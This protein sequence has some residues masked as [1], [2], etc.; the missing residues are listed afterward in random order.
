MILKLW[1]MMKR[2][3]MSK[4]TWTMCISFEEKEKLLPFL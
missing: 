4:R 2:T 1:Q 3:T